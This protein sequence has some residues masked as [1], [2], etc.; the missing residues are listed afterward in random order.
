MEIAPK[1]GTVFFF[2][3]AFLYPL[4]SYIHF[5]AKIPGCPAWNL[6]VRKN[7]TEKGAYLTTAPFIW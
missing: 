6:C 5:N 4:S 3:F 7:N 1:P 2:R